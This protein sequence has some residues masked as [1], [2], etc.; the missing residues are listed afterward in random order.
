MTVKELMDQLR[1]AKNKEAKVLFR[2]NDNNLNLDLM[3][4]VVDDNKGV[5]FPTLGETANA[6]AIK[7]TSPSETPSREIKDINE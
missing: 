2:Y 7:L 1:L 6:V 4:E 5:H 3:V